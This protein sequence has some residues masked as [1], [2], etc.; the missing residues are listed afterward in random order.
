MKHLKRYNE[1]KEDMEYLHQIF[2]DIIEDYG[3]RYVE[4]PAGHDFHSYYEI[5]IPE[6]I[7]K[8]SPRESGV[9]KNIDEYLD[10]YIEKSEKM[11]EL[12]KEIKTCINRIRDEFTDVNIEYSVTVNNSDLDRRTIRIEVYNFDENRSR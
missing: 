2:A 3:A 6:P 10:S 8:N 11:I 12:C 1:S 4:I 5:V 9:D 7:M